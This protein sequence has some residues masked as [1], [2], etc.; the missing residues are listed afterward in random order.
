[1][2]IKGIGKFQ[3][4]PATGYWTSELIKVP[5]LDDETYRFVLEDYDENQQRAEE[6][7]SAIR[8]FLSAEQ[9]VWDLAAPYAYG[10]YYRTKEAI[11]EEDDFP[12]VTNAFLIW[13][14]V[15][16]PEDISVCLRPG[17]A[18]C[19]YLSMDCECEWEREHGM[20]L[21]FKDGKKITKLG[22]YDGHLSNADSFN[23]PELEDVLFYG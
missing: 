5:L 9:S 4:D 21:V 2:D 15:T 23:N 22:P 14:F 8:N 19:A 1:M 12:Q 20:Q 3:K 10:Y 13:E 18:G 6:Y 7:F 16:F 11:V 17:S